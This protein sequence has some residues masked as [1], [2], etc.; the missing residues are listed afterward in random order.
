MRHKMIAALAA[1]PLAVA[2]RAGVARA[3]VMLTPGENQYV[4]AMATAGVDGPALGVLNVGYATCHALFVGLSPVSL[5]S[6]A[7]THGDMTPAQAWLSVDD[8]RAFLCPGA[9]Y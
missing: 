7:E 2:F 4:A 6:T 3:D 9:P 1:L 5:V 8:A